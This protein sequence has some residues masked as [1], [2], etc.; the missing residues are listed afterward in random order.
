MLTTLV[1]E[2]EIRKYCLKSLKKQLVVSTKLIR[3]GLREKH[4]M[5]K[6]K[7]LRYNV[8]VLSNI[9]VYQNVCAYTSY[10]QV[11]IIGWI[12]MLNC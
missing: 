11:Y 4:L 5:V 3:N 8:T 7:V 6:A 1:E 12:N 9:R 2:M 10:T